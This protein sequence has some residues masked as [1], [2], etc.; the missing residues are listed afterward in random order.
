LVLPLDFSF[1][2]MYSIARLSRYSNIFFQY[3]ALA[4]NCFVVNILPSLVII[5][6]IFFLFIVL[7]F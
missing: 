4:D 6:F 1:S 5:A 2:S 7:S 3:Q